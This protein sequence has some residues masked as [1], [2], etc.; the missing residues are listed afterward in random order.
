MRPSRA[1]GWWLPVQWRGRGELSERGRST[2]SQGATVV[3]ERNDPIV[4]CPLSFLWTF[5]KRRMEDD[6]VMGGGEIWMEHAHIH[7]WRLLKTRWPG[8]KMEPKRGGWI[9]GWGWNGRPLRRAGRVSL[10]NI[11]AFVIITL[12]TLVLINNAVWRDSAQDSKTYK[13]CIMCYAHCYITCNT[14]QR[15]TR[16]TKLFK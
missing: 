9:G 5:R 4:P 7:A 10:Y 12:I 8:R 11:F 15:D 16:P 3:V 6:D 13:M 2:D 14:C 1:V